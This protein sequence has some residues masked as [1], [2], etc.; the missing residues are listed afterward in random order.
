MPY[1]NPNDAVI[2][3]N[4]IQNLN[5]LFFDGHQSILKFNL[6]NLMYD[7]AFEISSKK[8]SNVFIIKVIFIKTI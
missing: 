5:Y 7:H 8:H 4:K 1:F 2:Y 3:T 6:G